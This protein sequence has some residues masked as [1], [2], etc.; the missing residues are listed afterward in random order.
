[1]FAL[2]SR[3]A[4]LCG[5][6]TGGLA[7]FLQWSGGWVQQQLNQDP[8]SGNVFVFVNP[9]RN[10]LK[11]LYWDGSGLWC[12]AKRLEGGKF[13]WPSGQGA[14]TTVRPEELMAL[15]SG[16]EVSSR[17]GWFRKTNIRNCEA[18]NKCV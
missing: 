16:L 10:R 8:T 9:R 14:A 6:D 13:G 12:C 7:P 18:E 3:H 15:L 5:A 17:K 1:M 4:Y 2:T 11:V